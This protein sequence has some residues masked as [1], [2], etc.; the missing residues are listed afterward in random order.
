VRLSGIDFE[1]FGTASVMVAEKLPSD[2][3]DIQGLLAQTA[4]APVVSSSESQPPLSG[5]VGSLPKPHSAGFVD[6]SSS[7]LSPSTD[8]EDLFGVP[9][10]LPSE[11]GNNKDDVQ[12]IFSHAPVLSP[13]ESLLKFPTESNPSECIT[14]ET[15][16]KFS[17]SDK[18]HTSRLLEDSLNKTPAVLTRQI[19]SNENSMAVPNLSSGGNLDIHDAGPPLDILHDNLHN[20]GEDDDSNDLFSETKMPVPSPRREK[21]CLFDTKLDPE[22]LFTSVRPIPQLAIRNY[23]AKEAGTSLDCPE[24]AG[25][26]LR[27]YLSSKNPLSLDDEKPPTLE[28]ILQSNSQ[29]ELFGSGSVKHDFFA[30]RKD[31]TEKVDM[32]FTTDINNSIH[33]DSGDELFSAH[34]NTSLNKENKNETFV[35]KSNLTESKEICDIGDNILFSSGDKQKQSLP[36]EK[37]IF[38]SSIKAVNAPKSAETDSKS[39]LFGGGSPDS[40][41]LFFSLTSKNKAGNSIIKGKLSGIVATSAE[42]SLFDDDSDDIFGSDKSTSKSAISA[43][44][45]SAPLDSAGQYVQHS[46]QYIEN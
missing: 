1:G 30:P 16:G 34:T 35:D 18:L 44:P 41:D 23:V 7:L 12:N 36:T 20:C 46:C 37:G 9:Q 19:S 45:F 3:A 32:F 42:V 2:K 11:Y 22:S 6:G 28:N 33:S 10:D 24:N 17:S 4:E 43:K 29:E 21:Q 15:V 31:F 27:D 38:S 26:L 39:G 13:L 40:D 25:P 14:V 5:T 8:E